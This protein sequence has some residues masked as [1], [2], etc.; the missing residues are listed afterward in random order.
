MKNLSCLGRGDIKAEDIDPH[1]D[2]IVIHFHGGGF[3]AMSSASHQSYTRVWAN[4]LKKTVFS[5]DYRLAPT[6]PF[7]A[8]VDDCWQTYNW[9]LDNAMTALGIS[10]S[11][12]IVVGDSAGGNLALGVV[13]RA[14]KLGYRVPDGL[15]LA[16]PALSV[17]DKCFSPSLLLSIDDQIVPYSLLKFCA[18]SYIPP[19][20]KPDSNPY[21]SPVCA[22]D[23]IL[24]QLPPVRI[25]IGT[26]DPLHD[27]SWRFMHKLTKLKKDVKMVVYT[28]MPH[29][30]LSYDVPNGMKESKQC[31]LETAAI[32]K[33]LMDKVP[34]F[35][36]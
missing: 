16:Y 1:F 34:S 22:S 35:D 12:V 25:V 6:H 21:L 32:I 8:A 24:S 13:Y 29:G 20:S 11:K 30:F 33:E 31:I 7:P 26:R 5:I 17:D 27:E 15:V 14:I 28:E 18:D 9:I 10:P 23:E 3:I 19:D 36:N 4:T 2:G